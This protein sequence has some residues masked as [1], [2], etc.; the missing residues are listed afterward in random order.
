MDSSFFTSSCP[1]ISTTP[2]VRARLGERSQAGRSAPGARQAR[3]SKD[4]DP[5]GAEGAAT[6]NEALLTYV[7]SLANLSSDCTWSCSGDAVLHQANCRSERRAASCGPCQKRRRC[8]CVLE[9]IGT[10][11]LVYQH[12]NSLTRCHTSALRITTIIPPVSSGVLALRS[13]G[14]RRLASEHPPRDS[15]FL[16]AA[17]I[18]GRQLRVRPVALLWM[19]CFFMRLEA[20]GIEV[21][22]QRCCGER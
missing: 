10:L 9:A 8:A 17:G 18:S 2:S 22:P 14:R 19:L 6:E 21:R 1:I 16:S 5:T 7:S 4:E 11:I 15:R 13:C 20:L 12:G 3:P